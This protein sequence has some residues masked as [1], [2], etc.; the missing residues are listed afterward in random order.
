[1]AK[2]LE[3]VKKNPKK[4]ERGLDNRADILHDARFL[5]GHIC[6]NSEIWLKAREKI[7][8]FGI[9]PISRYDSEGLG[10]NGNINSHIWAA[11]HNPGSKDFSIK[12][13]SPE[14]LSSARS[15]NEKDAVT[16]KKEFSKI[17]DIRLAL[18]TLRTATHLIHPWNLS[19]ASLEYFLNSVQFGEKENAG[20]FEKI[21]FITKFIDEVLANNAE[22]WDD[23][24]P[25][26]SANK[27]SNK[28]VAD[29]MTKGPKTLQKFDQ[30]QKQQNDSSQNSFKPGG[31]GGGGFNNRTFIPGYMCKR[32]NFNMCPFQKDDSCPAPWNSALK[33]KHVC[34]FTLPDKSFC[35]KNHSYRD[36]K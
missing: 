15:A 27:L 7:G 26:M 24:K 23:S 9:D 30:R 16:C 28:W 32:Y 18:N 22:A 21:N 13:L 3:K 20:N 8:I 31:V 5:G 33:L 35:Q 19:I 34:A 4:V 12:M 17:N 36:H 11:L 29:L 10:M 1:M 6:K 25:F 2:N 14:A